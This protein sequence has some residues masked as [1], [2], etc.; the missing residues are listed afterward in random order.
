MSC[1]SAAHILVSKASWVP[2]FWRSRRAM[3]HVQETNLIHIKHAFLSFMFV[4]TV[5]IIFLYNCA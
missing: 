1:D 5:G 2:K 4:S 3:Q